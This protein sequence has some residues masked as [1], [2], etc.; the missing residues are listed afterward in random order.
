MMLLLERTSSFWPTSRVRLF[1][2]V[3]R[4][5]RWYVDGRRIDPDQ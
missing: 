1:S 4:L 3:H 2:G 5:K